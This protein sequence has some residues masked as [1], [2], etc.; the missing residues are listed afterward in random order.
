[1]QPDGRTQHA[2]ASYRLWIPPAATT[3]GL[4]LRPWTECDIPAM[5]AAHSDPE[6][7]RWLRYPVGSHDRAREVIEAHRAA[8]RAGT[9]FSFAVLAADT[10]ADAVA[11]PVGSISIRG[12]GA[13][14]DAAEVGY[15]VAAAARGRGIAPRALNAVCEWAFRQPRTRP[16]TQLKLIHAV[17][18][19]ASCRVAAKA[20][21]PLSELLPPQPPEFPGDGHLHIRTA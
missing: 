11:D 18:N 8:R 15:W 9:G 17:G 12:L 7:R 16:L 19:Q 2:D 3:P 20:D 6:L 13:T 14:A 5:V 1:L 21:F 10:P 4:M